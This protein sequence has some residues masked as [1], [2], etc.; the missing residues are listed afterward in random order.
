MAFCLGLFAVAVASDLGLT[1]ATAAR[2]PSR[3]AVG[4]E[5]GLAAAGYAVLLAGIPGPTS[6]CVALVPAAALVALGRTIPV[7]LAIESLIGGL[8]AAALIGG[9]LAGVDDNA[10]RI[11]ATAFVFVAHGGVLIGNRR[12]IRAPNL[13]MTAIFVLMTIAA[14]HELSAFRPIRTAPA[15][16]PPTAPR[17]TP[18]E[19]E[20]GGAERMLGRPVP[21]GVFVAESAGWFV[22]LGPGRAGRMEKEKPEGT[23]RI[24][25]VGSSSTFGSGL[26]RAEEAW[27]ARLE[28]ALAG[29]RGAPRV[30]VVNAG[31]RSSTTF[32][33]LKNLRHDLM[34][35]APDLVIVCAASND[36]NYAHGPFTEEELFRLSGA[37]FFDGSD[38]PGGGPSPA[39]P[40][41]DDHEVKALVARAQRFLSRSE[42]YARLRR[43][44]LD[45][46]DVSDAAESMAFARA[47]AARR[48]HGEFAGHGDALPRAGRGHR[49]RRGKRRF[50][51]WNPTRR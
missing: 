6:V 15:L 20:T 36:Q 51:I 41:A 45:V 43:G 33:M 48:F 1:D 40:A 24:M 23:F 38:L 31:I 2:T 28:A 50:P 5:A 42:V 11:A 21:A 3:I 19:H 35:Y 9:H 37:G 27:P 10:F 47:C 49:F 34:D 29:G 44:V 13:I 8:L 22:T 26:E 4:L 25:A 32:G 30:E 17:I 7:F 18:G 12:V 16:D 14:E 46:R 39:A